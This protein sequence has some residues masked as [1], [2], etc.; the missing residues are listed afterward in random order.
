[1][2]AFVYFF[3]YGSLGDDEPWFQRADRSEKVAAADLNEREAFRCQRCE[4][5]V[6]TSAAPA[7]PPRWKVL[8]R[9][10]QQGAA[11]R[12][13]VYGL[14]RKH[15]VGHLEASIT[16]DVFHAGRAGAVSLPSAEAARALAEAL[17]VAGVA[18]EIIE[19]PAREGKP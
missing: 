10:G 9:D 8:F 12:R 1:L 2:A 17:R 13:S 3:G 14:L 5:V 7:Q 6:V 19:P 4:I 16:A 18:V 11:T 15:R